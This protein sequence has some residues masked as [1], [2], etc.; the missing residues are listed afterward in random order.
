MGKGVELSQEQA[1]IGW[2]AFV[3]VSVWYTKAFINARD[4]F[5]KGTSVLFSTHTQK[6][7]Y[8]FVFI[9]S[10]V[11]FFKTICCNDKAEIYIF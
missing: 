9:R 10:T 5:P 4:P 2:Q 3:C 11:F 7:N 1:L 6:K 8:T